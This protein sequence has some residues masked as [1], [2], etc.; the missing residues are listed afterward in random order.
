VLLYTS[1]TESDPKGAVHSHETLGY[2]DRSVIAHFGLTPDDVVFMPS[3]IAHIT[4]VLYGFHLATILGTTFVDQDVW[5]PEE[6]VR[7]VGAEGCTFMVAATSFLPGLTYGETPVRS[8]RVFACGGADVP[9]DLI[10][11]ADAR[12]GCLAVR[13]YGSTEIPT[14]TMGHADDTPELRARTRRAGGGRGGADDPR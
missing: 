5:E 12:L 3:P 13:V 10:R 4:G 14:L 1:G 2:E 7:L 11:D 9:P 8:L 6:G